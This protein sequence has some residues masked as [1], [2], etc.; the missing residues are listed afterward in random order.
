MDFYLGAQDPEIK[1]AAQIQAVANILGW[2][3]SR[4]LSEA[5]GCDPTEGQYLAWILKQMKFKNIV[6]PEDRSRVGI[7][8][9]ILEDVKRIRPPGFILDINRYRTVAD[10]EEVTDR[11]VEAASG[12]EME[13]PRKIVKL[14]EGAT[15]YRES[16]NYQILEVTHPDTCIYLARGTKWCTS[17][18]PNADQYI[19]R[20]GKLYVI[21]IRDRNEWVVYGQYTPDF[22]QLM[23][24]KNQPLKIDDE[25][26]ANVIGPDLDAP[27]AANQAFRYAQNVLDGRWPLGE[28][29]ILQDPRVAVNYAKSVVRG[30]WPEAE[31]IIAAN[32]EESLLYAKL[33][34]KGPWP[35]GERAIAEEGPTA[36]QYAREI[37]EDRFPMGEPEIAKLPGY[38]LLYARD[39]LHGRFLEAEP[40][41]AQDPEW[42]FNY[43][44]GILHDRFPEGELA[45][46]S[47][48]KAA[49]EYA[50]SIIQERWPEGE[51]AIAKDSDTALAYA[52][53]LWGGEFPQGEPAIATDA[54]RSY[55]YARDVL[56]SRFPL[57]EPAIAKE[58]QWAFFYARDVIRGRWPEGEEVIYKRKWWL[59]EYEELF[60][61]E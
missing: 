12:R 21:L 50:T 4:V 45:I 32:P 23:N 49:Y 35:A 37:L 42:A 6:L 38:A 43:A 52:M 54:R 8:L 15:L 55:I 53:G 56:H 28:S 10:L 22:S 36:Y 40:F 1:H 16:E 11:F 19:E 18:T 48:H 31:P 24:T 20:Y 33:I 17:E 5:L 46:A 14:P 27:D 58:P 60:Q 34:I 44:Q 39:I 51:A 47:D 2:A 57:G 13:R 9:D 41:I 29:L 30:R 26:L 7:A 3:P 25:E 61:N 59:K